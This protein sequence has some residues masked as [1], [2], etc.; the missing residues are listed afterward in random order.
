MAKQQNKLII[1]S[2]LFVAVF[3]VFTF[4]RSP[5]IAETF[6][7]VLEPSQTEP[8]MDFSCDPLPCRING[9][10]TNGSGAPL[11][12]KTYNLVVSENKI[13]GLPTVGIVANRG[14][15]LIFNFTSSDKPAYYF[16]IPKTGVGH[17]ASDRI[18]FP[19]VIS[20][21]EMSPGDYPVMLQ[22]TLDPKIAAPNFK[23]IVIR[24]Q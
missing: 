11:E 8:I 23:A 3:A 14:D 18:P 20:T 24:V 1:S 7:N 19:W 9:Q 5:E 6:S 15:I 10:K 12:T 4:L 22:D 16:F 13:N 21:A 17:E 2:L